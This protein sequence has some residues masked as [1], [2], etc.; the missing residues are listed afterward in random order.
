MCT[1]VRVTR[2]REGHTGG[3]SGLQRLK[4]ATNKTQLGTA[5]VEVRD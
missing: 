4:R 2:D 3:T 5:R 1:W